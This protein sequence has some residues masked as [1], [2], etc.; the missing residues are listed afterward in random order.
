MAKI[1]TEK[2]LFYVNSKKSV[3]SGII[4]GFVNGI[5]G[6]GGGTVCVYML[7]KNGIEPHKSHA[8]AVLIILC[9]S[10][11][12]AAIYFFKA[13]VDFKSIALASSGGIIGGAAGAFLLNKISDKWLHIIF[14]AV[15]ILTAWRMFL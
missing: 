5:F 12:S 14:G 8:S 9:V 7:E 1:I 6:S 15:M 11:V 4:I 3:L 10:I 13:H 2:E